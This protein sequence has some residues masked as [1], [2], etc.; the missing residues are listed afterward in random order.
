MKL[1]NIGCGSVYH[2]DWINLDLHPSKNVKYHNIKKRLPFKANSVDVIYHSHVLEHFTKEEGECFITDCYRI[3]KNGGIMR[4]VVPDLE[5]ICREYLINLENGYENNDT[6]AIS[7]YQ[8]NKIEMFDQCIRQKPG[9]EMV[10]STRKGKVNEDYILKRCGEELVVLFGKKDSKFKKAARNI[11]Y[12]LFSINPQTSGEA[13][14]WM[15]DKL[16]LSLLLSSVGFTDFKI[17]RYNQSKITNWEKY[18][19]DTSKSGDFARKPDSL[20]VEVKRK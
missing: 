19:L 3:L 4:V 5:S 7:H 12:S 8:W 1:V 14:K 15:Y 13:H 18:K 17:M 16:D 9:G 6:I 20:F 10:D 11:Y 2:P